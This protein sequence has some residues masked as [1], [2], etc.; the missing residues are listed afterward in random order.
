[1]TAEET[2]ATTTVLESRKRWQKLSVG[3]DDSDINKHSA[4]LNKG[5]FL[6]QGR[7]R[8]VKI[9][10]NKIFKKLNRM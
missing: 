1:V 4:G 2:L 7:Y 5:S 8:P 3:G 10:G 6:F 9:Q